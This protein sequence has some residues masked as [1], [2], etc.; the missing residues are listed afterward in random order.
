MFLWSLSLQKD[1]SSLLALDEEHVRDAPG[2]TH[3][4]VQ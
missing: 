2:H 3:Q 4:T 1:V